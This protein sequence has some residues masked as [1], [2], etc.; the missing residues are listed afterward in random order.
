M[1]QIN[2]WLA[3]HT[4]YVVDM[5]VV[6]VAGIVIAGWLLAAITGAGTRRLLLRTPLDG[7]INEVLGDGRRIEASRWAGRI[8]FWLVF[9]VAAMA[10]L[11]FLDLSGAAGPI[12]ALLTPALSYAWNL[13]AAL[14]LLGLGWV[15]GVALKRFV[16]AALDKSGIDARLS[17]ELADGDSVARVPVSKTLGETV[18]WL[19]LLLFLPAVLGALKIEGLLEPLQDMLRKFLAF[20]PNILAAG[21][22][23][24]I[25]WF[26]ARLVQRVVSNLL[27]AAGADQLSERVGVD[28][29]LGKKRL[30]DLVGLVVH[31]FIIIP[32]GIAALNALKID[33][34]T[35]PASQMLT[36]LLNALPMIFAAGLVLVISYFIGRIVADLVTNLLNGAGFDNI[37]VKLGVTKEVDARRRAPS[38]VG[39]DIVMIAIMLFAFIEAANLLG[40]GTLSALTADLIQLGG[41]ILLGLVIF[42]LGLYLANAAGKA[43]EGSGIQQSKLLS[44]L[45]RLAVIV[46]AGAMAL[47]QMGL[48][49]EIITTAFTLTLG[50]L[51]VA[52]AIA[53]GLGGRDAAADQIKNWRDKLNS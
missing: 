14:A 10:L 45:G 13:L 18:Q 20:L 16:T 44:T 41:R 25:G 6:K 33:A 30:S 27:A 35:R 8:V 39:G 49:N 32:V 40:F 23:F 31:A 48:A 2:S 4:G 19:V 15:I 46:L 21:I 42:A 5:T 34:I 43:I 11:E 3:E 37:L 24:V 29:A 38:N 9:L 26:V 1:D 17:S 7:W 22:I 52:F 28:N 53:F 36:T 51:A 47:R 12:G 50:A